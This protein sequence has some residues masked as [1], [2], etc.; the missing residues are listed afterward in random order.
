MRVVVGRFATLPT[1]VSRAVVVDAGGRLLVLGGLGP[2]DVT[3]ARVLAIDTAS[4]RS[5]AVGSLPQA[6]HDASGALLN[7]S[8][9]VFGGGAATELS[10]VQA[11]HS[12]GSGSGGSGSVVGHLPRPRSDSAAAVVAGTAYLVG[13]FDGARLDR[14]VVATSDG[15]TLR[16][17]GHL[18]HGVR[19]PAVTAYGGAVF[20]IGGELAT[21]PGTS[22]G[23]E[24]DLIQRFDPRSGRTTVVGRLPVGLGHAMAFSLGGDV[25]VAGGRHAGVASSRIWRVDPVTGKASPAGHLPLAMTDAGVAVVA[26]RVWLVGGETSGPLAPLRTVLLGRLRR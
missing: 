23:P 20:I 3:T 26:G 11:W 5:S 9:V 7:G 2:G 8:A 18:V 6:A 22:A 1:G 12:G 4:G 25:F 19:Y 24:S 21:T 14:A 10:A 17:V 13:G 16:V 15:R